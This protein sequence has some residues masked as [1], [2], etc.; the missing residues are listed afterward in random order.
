MSR[1]KVCMFITIH[2]FTWVVETFLNIFTSAP[3]KCTSMGG[4]MMSF[5]FFKLVKQQ[6]INTEKEESHLRK[7]RQQVEI[8]RYTN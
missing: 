7:L 1:W 6:E 3:L 5:L 4:M 8:L 2:R